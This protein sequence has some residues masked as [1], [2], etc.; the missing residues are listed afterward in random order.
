MMAFLGLGLAD[1]FYLNSKVI[2]ALWPDKKTVTELAPGEKAE[3]Q[4]NNQFADNSDRQFMEDREISSSSVS[5]PKAD[6]IPKK[7]IRENKPLMAA[8]GDNQFNPDKTNEI[9]QKEEES[10][11]EDQTAALTA[12]T[13][14][15]N[16]A[17]DTPKENV[18]KQDARVE[19]KHVRPTMV[20][21]IVVRF[22]NGE[23]KLPRNYRKTLLSELNKVEINDRISV[24]I[25]GHTDRRGTGNFDNEL[26]SQQRADYV[27]GLLKQQG[28]LGDKITARGHGDSQPLDITDSPEAYEKN[29]RAE[30]KIF[31]DEP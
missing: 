1:L 10:I 30:I 8:K 4:L 17:Q 26:L 3:P 29:R 9:N 16:D 21:K 12:D 23:Y 27:A 28:F 24:T 18:Q 31:K 15:E 25:D 19:E 2:P 22:K 6:Q 7:D 20:M 13:I 11:S 5:S 14:P